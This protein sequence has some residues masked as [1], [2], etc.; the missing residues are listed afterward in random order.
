MAQTKKKIRRRE[1]QVVKID[2]GA[3]KSF[4]RVLEEPLFAFYDREYDLENEP[5]IDDICSLPI[6]FKIW[7]MNYAITRGLWEVIGCKPLEVELN[8]PPKF[9]K[10]DAISGKLSIYQPTH[11][12]APSSERPA[13]FDEVKGLESAAVWDPQHV[14][15]RLRDHFAH[16]PNR[17]VESLK[18]KAN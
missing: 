13:T 16:R 18:L 9:F 6:A 15:D 10:Q 2:L 5:H 1:G 12:L 8:V 7:V 11:S 3:T 4:A 17:W 14:E